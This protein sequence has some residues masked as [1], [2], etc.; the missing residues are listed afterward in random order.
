MGPSTHVG[1]TCRRDLGDGLQLS[2]SPKNSSAPAGFLLIAGSIPHH[3][4]DH[5]FAG[6][7]VV[8]KHWNVDRRPPL[9]QAGARGP[10][11]VNAE[12]R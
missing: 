12:R 3:G 9:T 7:A 10:H 5:A 1:A 11:G 6:L 4:E 8:S 2:T